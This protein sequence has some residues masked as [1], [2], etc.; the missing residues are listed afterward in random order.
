MLLWQPRASAIS[1]NSFSI[2]M[3]TAYWGS[4]VCLA[5]CPVLYTQNSQA[6]TPS[7]AVS[8]NTYLR[9]SPALSNRTL[10]GDGNAFC[11]YFPMPWTLC[12]YWALDS[13]LV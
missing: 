3:A 8:T 1:S 9:L 11:L 10:C 13:N 6:L 2:I 7:C 4:L 5:S 12:G